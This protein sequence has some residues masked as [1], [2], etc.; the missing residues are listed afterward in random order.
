MSPFY[1]RSVLVIRRNNYRWH[2]DFF[3][4][5]EHPRSEMQVVLQNRELHG[6][7][8][9]LLISVMRKCHRSPSAKNCLFEYV[10]SAFMA[11]MCR[12]NT[13]ST[14]CGRKKWTPKFFRCFLRNRL[15]F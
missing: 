9:Y 13:H 8:W 3:N 1:H 12:W 10:K 2:T 5:A 7:G 14:G 4:Y 15:G 6:C 11:E